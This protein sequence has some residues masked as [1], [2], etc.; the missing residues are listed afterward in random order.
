MKQSL[1][2]LI[3]GLHHSESANN[4]FQIETSRFIE[5]AKKGSDWSRWNPEVFEMYFEKNL[6]CVAKLGQGMMKTPEREAIKRHW[7]E[8]APHLKAIA[9]SQDVPMWDEYK[10]IRRI[11]HRIT[12]KKL[13][14][15]TNRMLAGL[16][17]NLLCTECD[18]KRINE[19][20]DYLRRYTDADLTGHDSVNWEKASHNILNLFKSVTDNREY[21]RLSDTP[22]KLLIECEKRFG[23][24]PRK[25]LVF[26]N[27]T[28]WHHAEALHEIGF[29]SW[30]MHRTNFAIGD[31]VFLFM[32]DERRI[33]F[34]TRVVADNCARGD[35]KYRVD[36]KTSTHL[37]YKLELVS[38]SLNDNLNEQNLMRH[39]F[40]GGRSIQTPLYNNP[41]L[42]EYISPYFEDSEIYDY[43]EIQNPETVYEGAKKVITVNSYERNRE[44][45]NMCIAV[46]G[47]KCAVCGMN[48]EDVY[49]ELGRGFIH[50][51]HVVPISSIG[52][53]YEL[54]PAKDLIPVCPNCHAMLHRKDPPYTINELTDKLKLKKQHI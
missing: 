19:L 13:N 7:A 40:N 42:F 14:V 8:L 53:E 39:G 51:H 9:G 48:F 2:E 15:A 38:E 1:K 31:E 16:Q 41:E 5:E 17:P 6:N 20:V 32:S 47:C 27:R 23:K 21:W 18:I 12:E 45:R 4:V 52:K 36:R 33:R 43:D 22:W 37:T 50:V 26:C 46:H 44:A 24:L 29:I 30:T 35:D 49:G 11:V 3:N 25:W 28:M 34:K 10:E 54:K